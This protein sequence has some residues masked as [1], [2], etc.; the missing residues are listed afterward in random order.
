MVAGLTP[1]QL[2][3][4]LGFY[5]GVGL[6]WWDP[7]VAPAWWV[8]PGGLPRP[9]TWSLASQSYF[10]VFI[11]GGRSE[12]L[13]PPTGNKEKYGWLARPGG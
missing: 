13:T 10:M 5:A 3:P 6:C 4:V 1:G 2:A 8:V 9:P 11:S 12:L 7:R